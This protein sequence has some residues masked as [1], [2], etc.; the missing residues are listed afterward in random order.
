MKATLPAH[1]PVRLSDALISEGAAPPAPIFVMPPPKPAN[2]TPLP[3]GNAALARKDTETGVFGA[4]KSSSS[5][6]SL[7]CNGMH[8][9]PRGWSL[10]IACMAALVDPHS[11]SASPSHLSPDRR[12]TGKAPGFFA[13]KARAA[14]LPTFPS[15]GGK[16]G[17]AKQRRIGGATWQSS[18][19]SISHASHRRC[20]HS[21]AQSGEEEP[22]RARQSW[23]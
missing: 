9:F 2:A 3:T 6:P 1:L 20:V 7:P 21:V 11:V 5:S 12:G 14:M 23:G 4:D 16:G 10:A 18:L 15:G 8:T 13:G 22:G 19:A 17:A